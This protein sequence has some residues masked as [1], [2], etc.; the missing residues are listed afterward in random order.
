MAAFALVAQA[1]EPPKALARVTVENLSGK[2]AAG[3]FVTFG[4]PFPRGLV[5]TERLA[6]RAAGGLLPSQVDVKRHYDD[7]SVRFAIFTAE[8]DRLPARGK[9]ALEIVPSGR[10][11]A[12]GEGPRWEDLLAA[13]FDAAVRFALRDGRTVVA[14]ASAF[15]P[16]HA[17]PK[18]WLNGPLCRE[19]LLAGAPVDEAGQRDR[20]LRVE[21]HVRA[22]RGLRQV[23]LC[24]VAENCWDFGAGD[25]DIPYDVA[26][27]L[28]RGAQERQV[29]A[30]AGVRH[31]YLARWR[32]DFWWP[33]A[34]PRVHIA[35]D[36][37]AL[38][39]SG[40]VPP[41]DTSIKI[42]EQ[43][44][45]KQAAR[46]RNCPH[47]IL[48]NGLIIKYF[49][50]TGGRE[51]IGPYPAW[52]ARYLIS[53]DPRLKEI[54]LGLG[55]LAG[56]F[57]YHVRSSKTGRV[58]TI[59]ERPMFWLD[60]RGKDKLPGKHHSPYTVDQA[61]QPSL[62]YI[63]YLVT[64]DKYY[65]DEMYFWAGGCLLSQWF[66]PRENEKGLLKGD[67]VRGQA[68]AFRQLVD[69]AA[70]GCDGDP[71]VAYFDEKIRN[72]IA[73]WTHWATRP[74]ASPFGTYQESRF[75]T[76][77]VGFP[78]MIAV[79]PWQQDFLAWAM[80]HAVRQGYPEAAV[81][82]DYLLR[83][84]VGRFT[85]APDYDPRHGA[86]YFIIVG[87]RGTKQ[88]PQRLFTSWKQMH[89]ATFGKNPR[90]ADRGF[91]SYGQIS[92][93]AL[94]IAVRAGIPKADQALR[95]VE[96]KI[97]LADFAKDPTWAFAN[98][99]AARGP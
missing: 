41:Y 62:A 46:W 69:A 13:G 27:T 7:G 15:A 87:V 74:N 40:A 81:F 68:W 64:G 1:Q 91:G 54:C 44:C 85:N 77:R 11:Q 8:I 90:A 29:Y 36:L 98:P 78:A 99:L 42:P 88:R 23:R 60:E 55:D 51:D 73:Y 22:Y 93:M 39:A 24:C 30:K 47:D 10:P 26:I 43:V 17:Q 25:R 79:A 71:E 19:F 56:S 76:N 50:T 34:P 59:D 3:V 72:N 95:Y 57:S 84:T 37:R 38:I 45:A 14:R 92:R 65:L 20:F 70:Y 63:P 80:D 86:P 5:R 16:P 53:Q 66:V 32:K 6:L 21:F 83:F 52:A 61:H 82:R 97:N 12:V 18:L 94:T 2:P 28:G 75:P 58:L 31:Y 4:H 49:P 67:Q 96:S 48:E 35:H 89:E 33:T 9:L